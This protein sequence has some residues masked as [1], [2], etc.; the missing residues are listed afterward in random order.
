MPSGCLA[1]ASLAT[2]GPRPRAA[3][4]AAGAD[5]GP[6]PGG[7]AGR[8]Q[9]DS[10]GATARGRARPRGGG[11][12]GQSA[13]QGRAPHAR[14]AGPGR[15][16][17]AHL[18]GPR[19]SE[20]TNSAQHRATSCVPAAPGGHGSV[21]DAHAHAPL[22]RLPG[23]CDPGRHRRLGASRGRPA[24]PGAAASRRL[25]RHEP[26]YPEEQPIPCDDS[27]DRWDKWGWGRARCRAP[28]RAG[29]RRGSGPDGPARPSWFGGSGRCCGPGRCCGLGRRRG[30]IGGLG[31]CRGRGCSGGAGASDGRWT[32]RG[33]SDAR[34]GPS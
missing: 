14:P 34:W 15:G 10:A 19:G 29:G 3:R 21:R 24:L 31:G 17:G 20:S 11:G 22:R 7:S 2:G 4:W 18:A 33:E 16:P 23:G 1:H 25:G 32:D 5:R 26:A 13:G 27:A 9:D 6:A 28:D 30:G 12:A 8:V